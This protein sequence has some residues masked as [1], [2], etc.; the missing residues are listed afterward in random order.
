MH[1]RPVARQAEPDEIFE[2]A[3]VAELARDPHQRVGGVVRAIQ[4]L[5]V[6]RERT[7][8]VVLFQPLATKPQL[9]APG[10]RQRGDLLERGRISRHA[11]VLVRLRR[12]PHEAVVLVRVHLQRTPQRR[13]RLRLIAALG[14]HLRQVGQ[15]DGGST[16]LG[17]RALQRAIRSVE[18]AEFQAHKRGDD[19]RL[20]AG[21]ID[22]DQAIRRRR[23]RPDH[24]VVQRLDDL[25]RQRARVVPRLLDRRAED[26]RGPLRAR[27]LQLAP[28]LVVNRDPLFRPCYAR[29]APRRPTPAAVAVSVTFALTLQPV[30][31]PHARDYR[32]SRGRSTRYFCDLIAPWA[33]HSD[34][35]RCALVRSDSR[36]SRYSPRSA[37]SSRPRCRW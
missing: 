14:E 34:S 5:L 11:P 33:S 28:A 36:V 35:A 23:D 25:A 26:L 20:L 31:N 15:H 18:V 4:H 12:P 3:R 8:A 17:E 10:P 21:V 19:Q 27:D 9:R 37:P 2:R 30:P 24:V 16:V 6:E 7:R 29:R 1:L 32:R 22:L 13:A